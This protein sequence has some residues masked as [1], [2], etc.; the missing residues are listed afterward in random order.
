MGVYVYI[1]QLDDK[2]YYTGISKN[3]FKRLS[4]H[5]SKQC[6][7]TRWALKVDI[8]YYKKYNDYSAARKIEVR[9]KSMGAR[10]YLSK[11]KF[12][13][14]IVDESDWYLNN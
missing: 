14:C 4:Q 8:K 1:L 12:E 10:K 3:V 13:K 11:L 7:S 6:I 9:I 5:L 2:S